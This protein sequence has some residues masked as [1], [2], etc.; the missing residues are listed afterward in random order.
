MSA[1]FGNDDAAVAVG[2]DLSATTRPFDDGY[3]QRFSSFS[4]GFPSASPP[5][6]AVF[7]LTGLRRRRILHP[8]P[9]QMQRE[10]GFILWEWRRRWDFLLDPIISR[11]GMALPRLSVRFEWPLGATVRPPKAHAHDGR[12]GGGDRRHRL[13]SINR[14]SDP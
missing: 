9:D 6:A 14:R 11:F 3:L 8:E 12:G 1:A 13:G 5:A 7:R 2:T 10:E 4:P